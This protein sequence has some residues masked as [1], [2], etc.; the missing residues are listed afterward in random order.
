M[1]GV[2]IG[3]LL[4]ASF[5]VLGAGGGVIAVPVMMATLGFSLHQAM[6]ASLVVVF[7]ASATATVGHSR[8]HRVEWS[9]VMWLAP[10]AAVGAVLGAWL[11]PQVPERVL[12]LA[13]SSVLVLAIVLV[14]LRPKETA[15]LRW[16]L[17]LPLLGVAV[18]GLTGLLGVGG[19]FLW[20]PLLGSM[21]GLPTHRAV[22]TSAA[23]IT[24]SSFAGALTVVL[25]ASVPLALVAPLAVGAMGGALLG[26]PLSGRLPS[27]AIRTG[28]VVVASLVAGTMALRAA[29]G[30][31]PNGHSASQ[32]ATVS[33]PSARSASELSS[34]A[35]RAAA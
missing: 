27:R 35:A 31:L 14:L 24:S 29:K 30:P 7:V 33:A 15:A 4:G 6:G 28:F 11:H 34:N 16:R 18:G 19:G 5:A 32:R 21:V 26:V 2:V 25:G 3:V 10:A 17:G 13:L 9:A 8:A 20:V 22:A 12:A 1:L 23:L